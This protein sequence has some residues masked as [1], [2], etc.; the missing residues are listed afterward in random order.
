MYVRS[1]FSGLLDSDFVFLD[2]V[3]RLQHLSWFEFTG[4]LNLWA[5]ESALLQYKVQLF[6]EGH[7]NVRNRPYAFEIYFK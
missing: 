6:R 2:H 5:D 4:I 7:K 1:T 3:R